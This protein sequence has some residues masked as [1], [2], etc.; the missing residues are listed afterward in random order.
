MKG[1]FT[2]RPPPDQANKV[3]M[4]TIVAKDSA[5][6]IEDEMAAQSTP[7]TNVTEK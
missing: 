6:N 5:T 3:Q 1:R 2:V 4:K 7:Q